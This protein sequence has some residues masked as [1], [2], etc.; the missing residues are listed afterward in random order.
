MRAA[1][2]VVALA[3]WPVLAFA[4]VSIDARGVVS[5][6]G[7]QHGRGALAIGGARDRALTELVGYLRGPRLAQD[8]TQRSE[9]SVRD[10]AGNTTAS[11]LEQQREYLQRGN[12][13]QGLTVEV[14]QPWLQGNDTCVLVTLLPVVP[15]QGGHTGAQGSV[16]VT[17]TVLGQGH[18]FAGETALERAERD[19]LRRAVSQVVG[20]W[21]T[22]QR[23]ESGTLDLLIKDDDETVA[24]S[25]LMTHQ[26]VSRS[27]GYVTEWQLLEHRDLPRGG[28]EVRI[29]ATVD[30]R[31]VQNSG[32]SLLAEL[33][34]PRVEVE[35][36]QP[37]SQ[38]LLGWL[39]E[40]NISVAR[41]SPIRIVAHAQLREYGN[42]RRVELS[43]Q[44][45]DRFGNVYGDW[46]NDPSLVALPDSTS[47]LRDLIE[48]HLATP[49]QKSSLHAALEQAFLRV[50]QR[51]GL[52]REVTFPRSLVPDQGRL[53]TVL[54]TMGG[55]SDVNQRTGDTTVTVQL[56]Y[57]GATDAL[58]TALSQALRHANLARTPDVV[59]DNDSL[60][61]IR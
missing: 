32:Q 25:E 50:F 42:N 40:Q 57:P 55:V 10:T 36:V 53:M 39:G 6:T 44:V 46:R 45:V 30:R 51:G 22:E 19:A 24:M 26:L 8:L 5:A 60:I 11:V 14:S 47:V 7:C 18:P 17:V 2:A 9:L 43:I 31:Q 38:I 48:V 34:S 29:E 58:A 3:L 59:I 15:T 16:F 1:L 54:S 37:V 61:L 35:A 41:S 21:L 49:L 52:L 12:S 23:S 20:V 4:E 56:R 33:G 27:S 13:A 28:V